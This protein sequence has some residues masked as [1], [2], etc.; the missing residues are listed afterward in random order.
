MKDY[1]KQPYDSVLIK[2]RNDCN[3][4]DVPNYYI[5]GQCEEGQGGSSLYEGSQDYFILMVNGAKFYPNREG[6]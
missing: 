3:D 2:P 1:V 5:C 4:C 6:K